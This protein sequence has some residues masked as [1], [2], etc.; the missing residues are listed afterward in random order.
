MQ[1]ERVVGIDFENFLQGCN[2]LKSAGLRLAFG[3]PQVP[4]TEIHHRLC[5]QGADIGIF[6]KLLPNPAHRLRITGV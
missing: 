5:E 2:D 6:G 4:R 1:A 3:G